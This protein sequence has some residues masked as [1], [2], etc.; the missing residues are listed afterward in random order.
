MLFSIIVPTCNR[1][2]LLA[3]CLDLLAPDIQSIDHSWYEVVVT[4]D[5]NNG[6]AKTMI[7]EK[8]P[9]VQ[10]VEGP[11]RGPASNRNN[12]A[13]KAKGEWLIF[14]DDDCLP[15]NNIIEAYRQLIQDFPVTKV[16]EGKIEAEG[17]RESPLDYAPVNTEG[18][19]LWSCN[20][21]V[22]KDSFFS[23]GGFDEQFK[24]PHMEDIDLR[25]RLLAAGLQIKFAGT[26]AV[27][28][29]WRK[30]SDGKKLGRYQEMY[31]YY[32]EKH[33]KPFS[34]FKILVQI[35]RVHFSLLRKSVF[36]KDFFMAIKIWLEHIFTVI[37]NYHK[38]KKQYVGK[39]K[40]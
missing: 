38:W 10:W 14:L 12:G 28:H 31:I 2:D 7:A 19:H 24:Y 21:A 15:S 17:K 1:N 39:S 27:T 26:A 20:F 11:K 30:L 18:G 4:D 23:I 36:N 40:S 32:H 33:G 6:Q 22:R 25:E 3:K 13:K 37:L 9:W 5:G 34:F 16:F 35:S 29:P 8:Y